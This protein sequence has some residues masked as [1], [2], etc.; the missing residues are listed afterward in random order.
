M[1]LGEFGSRLGMGMGLSSDLGMWRMGE[2]GR[3]DTCHG[4][5][6]VK[7]SAGRTASGLQSRSWRYARW[8]IV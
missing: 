7:A 4:R 8:R 2:K 5:M 6:D 1:R 3:D